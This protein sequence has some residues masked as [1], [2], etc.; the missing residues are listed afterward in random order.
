MP[1][2]VRS[3]KEQVWGSVGKAELPLPETETGGKDDAGHLGTAVCS[4]GKMCFAWGESWCKQ[5][6][7]SSDCPLHLVPRPKKQSDAAGISGVWLE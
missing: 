5:V 7:Y 1:H 3:V 6:L 2:E 4:G